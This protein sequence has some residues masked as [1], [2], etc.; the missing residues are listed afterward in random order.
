MKIQKTISLDIELVTEA[1]R[2]K[3]MISPI[4]NDFLR[5]YLK[6]PTED[7]RK[8][9]KDVKADVNRLRAELLKKEAELKKTEKTEEGKKTIWIE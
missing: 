8:R 2:Q 5:E 6:L 4:I 9:A 7:N 3:L 1:K